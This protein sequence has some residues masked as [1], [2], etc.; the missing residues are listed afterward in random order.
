MDNN[1][2]ENTE[3]V[4]EE[5]E[6]LE[7]FVDTTGI[8][9]VAPPV[10]VAPTKVE[11]TEVLAE[12]T[13]EAETASV[14]NN[15]SPVQSP[16]VNNQPLE[17][18]VGQALTPGQEP[19]N[20]PNDGSF[21]VGEAM[22]EVQITDAPQSNF[23]YIMTI[24]LFVVL[25]V[26]VIFMPEIS[27]FITIMKAEKANETAAKI[28]T[29][30]LKCEISRNSSNLDME[31]TYVFSFTDNKFKKLSY[32]SVIRG[33]ANLDEAELDSLYNECET[34]KLYTSELA[35]VSV[36]CK[37][38]SGTLTKSQTLNYENINVD[39]TY[40]AYTEAGGVYPDYNYLEDMDDIEKNM[41]AAGYTCERYK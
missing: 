41:K 36:S 14:E 27:N 24:I 19:V 17:Q 25:G 2:N 9:P 12:A 28:T 4:N 13:T 10:A 23:K 5:T 11:E 35:G 1:V 6:V 40:T 38:S 16:V 20:G 29:G 26:A 7:P 31:Y 18:P 22:K 15:T 3:Y 21:V 39:E 8:V 37:L 32:E 34:L 33:D 30:T